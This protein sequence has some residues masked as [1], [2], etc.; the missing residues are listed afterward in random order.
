MSSDNFHT[1]I[2]II[3]GI[4]LT[5]SEILPFI[6]KIKSN[7]L[8]HFFINQGNKLLKS[9]ESEE[10]APLLPIYRDYNDDNEKDD[11]D[12]QKDHNK[13][14][15]NEHDIEEEKNNDHETHKQKDQPKE[16]KKRESDDQ[17]DSE[18][19]S[20]NEDRDRISRKKRKKQKKYTEDV[21]VIL[22]TSEEYELEFLKNYI[23]S[24]YLDHIIILPSFHLCNR[25]KFEKMGYKV[26]YDHIDD[27][28]T[29]KW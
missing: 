9:K 10:T 1:L 11:K 7:G 14:D 13:E 15:Q 4:L 20:T 16:L 26:F 12:D 18:D 24:H 2:T 6:S 29:L 21:K 8:L 27:K 3:T 19:P 22:R 17:H 25:E 23:T 28:Y 5:I